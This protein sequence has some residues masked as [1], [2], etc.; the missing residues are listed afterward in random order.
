MVFKANILCVP[1]LL[2]E[3]RASLVTAFQLFRFIALYSLI[4]F[5]AVVLCYFKAGVLGNWQYLY[6]VFFLMDD[7]FV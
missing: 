6:Q 2:A 1:L 5:S 7:F 3:G 4:Q